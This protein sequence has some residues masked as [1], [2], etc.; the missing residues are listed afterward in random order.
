MTHEE[1]PVLIVGGS[2]VG[3][4]TAMLLGDLGV[5]SLSVERHTGTAIH[6][7][8]GHFQ[9]GT[10][11][12]LRQVGLE[13][14]VREASARTY[15]PR[16]GIIE[17]QS[18]AGEQRA[19]YVEELNEGVE[20][21]SPTVRVFVNQDVLEPIL[22]RRAIELG[23][24]VRNRT[25]AVA[26]EQDD[27]GVTVTLRDLDAG[28]DST[29]R[30]RYVV[31]ADGNRSPT[32]DRLGIAMEGYGELSRSITIYFR[33]DCEPLLRDRNQ[34][35]IYV[36][37][38]ALRGFFRIDRS[39]GTGFLVINTVGEDVTTDEAVNVG[40]GL[41]DE[42]V[43][44]LLAAAIGA[45]DV[46]AEVIDVAHWRAESNVAARMREGRVFLA[47]D[48]AHVVPPN[49]GYGGNTGV[50]DARNLA[51]KLAAVVKGEAG[52]QLLH[53]Y[54]AERRPLARLTVEQAYTRYA[55]RVVP[56][57]GSDDAEP[58]IPDLTMELGLVMHSSAVVGDGSPDDGLLHMNPADVRGRPGTRAAHVDLGDGRSTID[59]FGRELVLLAPP[60]SPAASATTPAGV[61]L[62][63]V[64]APDFT[65]AYGI[66]AHG[67][68]LVRP[69]GIV[70]WRTSN[71]FAAGDLSAAVA[72]ILDAGVG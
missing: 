33:A 29:V 36:R 27:D 5:P 67:A 23:A 55:T 13:D 11:E 10:M 65:E 22:R 56:E 37:N 16:G 30:A 19:T 4:T 72:A 2:L 53:S 40:E 66:S 64:D 21:Y 17:V 58:F 12:M 61:A 60:G 44:Q 57:R 41:T 26:I 1:I 62:H 47:G 54:D 48:A 14:E 70:G 59:L 49:G 63:L 25:E 38:E 24:T 20:G 43:A 15:H 6:P 34:G 28:I 3:L 35:V 69:D 39:G 8:A 68:S 31:A 52:P 50:Q 51:W 18:L 9:L 42:R 46:P 32:R 7:R 71:G 45:P